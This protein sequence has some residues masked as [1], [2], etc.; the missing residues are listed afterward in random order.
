MNKNIFIL[1]AVLFS[2]ARMSGG[3]RCDSS[4]FIPQKP[5]Q[6]Q[7]VTILYNA[8]GT[9]LEFSDE[10]RA[11]VY[12][13]RDF[14][15]IKQPFSPQKNADGRWRLSFTIP[16]GTSFVAVKFAQGDFARPDASDNN[17]DK[18]Y[19][20]RVFTAAGKPAQGA[21]LA[22]AS[23]I[24]P[25]A[26]VEL[27]DYYMQAPSVDRVYLEELLKEV[28]KNEPEAKTHR[29]AAYMNL[30]KAFRREAFPAYLQKQVQALFT[31]PQLQEQLLTDIH[32][33]VKFQ[34]KDSLLSQEVEQHIINDFPHSAPARL[35]AHGN[36]MNSGRDLKSTIASHEDFLRRFPYDA[37]KKH[38]NNQGFIYYTIHRSLG[39]AYFDSK[40]FDKFVDLFQEVDFKTGNELMRWSITRAYMLNTVGKDTLYHISEQVLPLLI[41]R[42]KDYSY[43]DNPETTKERALRTAQEQLDDRLFT[44]ISLLNDVGEYEA[45]YK[46]LAQ[47]SAKGR[48]S[49]SDLNQIAMQILEKTGRDS[50]IQSLLEKSVNANAVT[51]EMFA[52]LK[53]IYSGLHGGSDEGYEAYLAS[54]KSGEEQNRLKAYVEKHKVDYPMPDFQLEA[55]DG[56]FVSLSEWK[57]KIVVVDFWATWCAPC[58]RAL[59][60]MQLLADKYAADPQVEVYLIGTMQ[61]GDY[62]SKSVHFLREEGY[63]FNHLHD[64]FNADT[65]SQ[66]V[67]FKQLV[68]P[69]FSDSSIP[70]KIVLKN[71]IIRYSSEGYSGSPSE[72]SDELSLVIETLKNEK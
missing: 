42:K 22:E 69:V 9:D 7:E 33:Y 1:C 57:D 47:L 46:Y 23:F 52:K 4:L 50:E 55:A 71:G 12:S 18:G 49:N 64:G 26:E 59:P 28:D 13:F 24:T 27:T 40:Q 6:G 66:N 67:L 21:Y 3:E 17:K 30:Q 41:S 19:A 39:A 34:A 14:Q 44:H 58:L 51:P 35:I 37:W 63:R 60:G 54:L 56:N 25:S 43:A 2:F 15:W 61:N 16:E 65:K 8:R 29:F 72:L 48:Y 68:G 45:A 32:L 5:V 31:R 70:R 38:P 10:V 53:S 11:L 62:K 36:L 20:T